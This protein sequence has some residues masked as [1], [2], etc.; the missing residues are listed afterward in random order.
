MKLIEH[1]RYYFWASFRRKLLDKYQEKYKN[2]YHGIVLDIGGRDRGKF[3]KPKD[4]VEK[5]IFADISPAH[6]PDIVLDVTKMD[7]IGNDSIDVISAME[8][9]EYVEK[10]DDAL[11]ECH[12]IL[13]KD[14][15]MVF[16]VPFLHPIADDP[17]DLQRWTKSMWQRQLTKQGFAIESIEEMGYFFTV[18]AEWINLGNKSFR[19]GK[20]FCYIFYPLLSLIAKLDTSSIVKKN[21]SLKLFTTGYFIIAKKQ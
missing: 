2:I 19:H 5:W 8:V 16:S 20:Y 13:K 7:I 1:V 17:C 4:K 10:I 18:L 6:N 9:F 15:K 3:K 21:T 12:R 11:K 14:G